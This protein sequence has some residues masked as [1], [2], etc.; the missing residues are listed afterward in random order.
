MGKSIVRSGLSGLAMLAFVAVTL[1]GVPA[2]GQQAA[3]S[4]PEYGARRVLGGHI[5]Q[6]PLLVR[7]P[8]VMTHVGVRAGVEFQQI[9]DFEFG[10]A[11]ELNLD[12]V[13]AAE[14]IDIALAVSDWFALYATGFMRVSLGTRV[15][16]V[17]L[18]GGE[19]LLAGTGGATIRVLEQRNVLV[20]LHA[21]GTYG[22]GNVLSL[23]PFLANLLDAPGTTLEAAIRGE[24]GNL[25][26]SPIRAYGTEGG[27]SAAV[28]FSPAISMQASAA[29]RY[30]LET[31]EI[32]SP[33]AGAVADRDRSALAPQ[34]GVA[35]GFD[36]GPFGIPVAA[37]AEYRLAVVM[38]E[39][40]IIDREAT[41]VHHAFALGL[42]LSARQDLQLGV[43]GFAVRG[44]EPVE[45]TTRAGT[46][47]SE[48]PREWGGTFVLRT[49]W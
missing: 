17:V 9:P 18:R 19:Y 33:E 7:S 23:G 27:I 20:S 26:L 42:Y 16:S 46:F 11:G 34:F 28:A 21:Q 5:L 43:T 36:V 39:N 35:L 14:A 32:F 1:F 31:L 41:D 2:L 47:G 30:S 4:S 3:D 38:S 24:A 15:G 22:G 29:L 49:F 45:V 48:E 10:E 6:V 8:L 12:Q 37:L 40:E 25:L 13:R 44:L